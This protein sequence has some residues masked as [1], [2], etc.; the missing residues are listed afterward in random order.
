MHAINDSITVIV[1]ILKYIFN[2]TYD[3]DNKSSKKKST[4]KLV[5]LKILIK[6]YRSTI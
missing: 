3:D 6:L 4:N 2:F 5:T 1:A